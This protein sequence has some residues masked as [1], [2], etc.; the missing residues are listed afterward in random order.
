[1]ARHESVPGWRFAC[2]PIVPFSRYSSIGSRSAPNQSW[3]LSNAPSTS[4]EAAA[5]KAFGWV[6]RPLRHPSSLSDFGVGFRLWVIWLSSVG[7]M[8]EFG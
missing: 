6:S 7:G 1:M 3:S 5:G 4:R 8:I 2:A